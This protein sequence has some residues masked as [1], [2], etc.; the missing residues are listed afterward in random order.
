MNNTVATF[1]E[2]K[3]KC[4]CLRV[5]PFEVVGNNTIQPTLNAEWTLKLVTGMR[6]SNRK[7]REG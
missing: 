6:N 4:D 1:Y 5:A 2:T 3:G 7:E